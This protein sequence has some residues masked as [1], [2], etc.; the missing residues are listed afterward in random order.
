M[1]FK[2]LTLVL[3]GLLIA[4]RAEAQSLELGPRLAVS[5]PTGDARDGLD[6]GFDAGVTAT[7]MT[8][9]M[10]GVGVDLGYQRWPGSSYLNS[11]V[12]ALFSRLGGLSIR[13]SEYTLSAF[14]ITGH[15]KVVAPMVGPAALWIQVGAGFYRMNRHLKLPAELLEAWEWPEPKLSQDDIT[16]EPGWFGGVGV[17]FKTSTST[18]LGLDA[19]Y[20]HLST[21]LGLDTSSFHLWPDAGAD[22]AEFR[23]GAHLLFGRW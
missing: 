7:I 21:K 16:T 3:V 15:A 9:S 18:K 2:I 13:G 4:A 17:D 22:L 6:L 14:Q 11:S 23:I 8:N 10:V 20:Y 12:D 1:R 5:M 19:S